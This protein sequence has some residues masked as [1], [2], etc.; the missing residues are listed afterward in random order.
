[1]LFHCQ[2]IWNSRN[3]EQNLFKR[4]IRLAARSI[5]K[6]HG[7]ITWKRHNTRPTQSTRDT[8]RVVFMHRHT[9]WKSFFKTHTYGKTITKWPVLSLSL[10]ESHS[11]IFLSQAK[12]LLMWQWVILLQK[13]ARPLQRVLTTR[14]QI[15]K[16]SCQKWISL[17]PSVMPRKNTFKI[18]WVKLW[19][20]Q[21][22]PRKR[23]LLTSTIHSMKASSS[24]VLYQSIRF[25]QIDLNFDKWTLFFFYN[26]W[27]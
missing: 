17:S 16:R 22:R 4:G 6:T 14:D 24:L 12:I 23:N 18:L 13:Q 2:I 5:N 11:L 8:I 10:K 9:L 27:H 19:T 25:W 15:W 7:M 26:W 20:R 21:L 1:M 3:N